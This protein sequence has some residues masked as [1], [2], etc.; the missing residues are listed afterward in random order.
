MLKLRDRNARHVTNNLKAA[1]PFERTLSSLEQNLRSVH[2]GTLSMQQNH[3]GGAS[4][5]RRGKAV[6]QDDER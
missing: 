4:P 5:E 1:V 3:D 2:H 6:G